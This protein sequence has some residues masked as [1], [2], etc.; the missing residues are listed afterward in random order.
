MSEKPT[1][2]VEMTEAN[3]D[4]DL[5]VVDPD[6][7]QKTKKLEIIHQTKKEILKIRRNRGKLI[8]EYDDGFRQSG[9]EIYESN[10]A[11][12]VA[13]YGSELLPLIEEGLDEGTL[14]KDDVTTR[15]AE[16][17]IEMDVMF[18][19]EFDGRI[20]DDDGDC[21]RPPETNTMVIYRQLDRIQRKLG[22]GL[23]LEEDKG[24]AEI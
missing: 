24:A 6:D 5:Y 19:I 23:D 1:D 7:Y 17:K 16:D 11:Q 13:L 12:A 18:F 21:I 3:E 9:I 15:I 2:S 4:R 22:L 20:L 8:Q 14:E 10:L